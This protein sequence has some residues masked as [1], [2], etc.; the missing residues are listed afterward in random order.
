MRRN[1]TKRSRTSTPRMRVCSSR[2]SGIHVRLRPRTR[3]PANATASPS[4]SSG[5][6]RTTLAS[7]ATGRARP[8][9]ARTGRAARHRRRRRVAVLHQQGGHRS[10]CRVA[11]EAVVVP[12]V[13]APPVVVAP[14]IVVVPPIES[15][16]DVGGR[17]RADRGGRDGQLAGGRGETELHPAERL[18]DRRRRLNRRRLVGAF[19]KSSSPIASTVAAAHTC[20]IMASRTTAH[21]AS[22]C[23]P[24]GVDRTRGRPSARQSPP[25]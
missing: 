17:R 11:S 14:P 24:P 8:A 16:L 19:R 4:T 25:G 23:G 12:I 7:G 20:P 6:R 1:E 22:P 2:R 9:R 15:N 18:G 5:S 13:V 10:R 3:S 21:V